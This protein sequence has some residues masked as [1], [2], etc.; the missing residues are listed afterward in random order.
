MNVEHALLSLP[1]DLEVSLLLGY[2]IVVLA[3]ARLMEW[4]AQV[5]FERARRYA[6]GGFHY[7]ANADHY[8]CPQGERLALHLIDRQE[9]V[10]VYRA[11]ASACAGCPVKVHC[12]PHDEG[13][14]IYRPLAVWAETDVGRF[15][16]WLSLLTAASAAALS[17]V[18]FLKWAGRPGTGLLI[19][20]L[21]GAAH[22][23]V[24]DARS[25]WRSAGASEDDGPA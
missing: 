5:H 10:A 14:H 21:L 7:D 25:V 6:E 19:V 24:R 3:G 4:L 16:Q 20:A 12:T 1:A 15:H 9:R 18:A 8:H 23:A 13:R 17:L 22:V 2:A 11:P